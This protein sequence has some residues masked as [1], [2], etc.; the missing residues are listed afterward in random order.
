LSTDSLFSIFQG[1]DTLYI[2]IGNR[3][4]GDDG[5]GPVIASRLSE[6]P[7]IRIKDAGDRPERAMNWALEIR[8][9]LVVFIDASD[10]GGLAGEIRELPLESISDTT[11]STHRIPL[12]LIAGWITSETG[13]ECRCIGIQPVSMALGEGLSPEVELAAAEIVRELR[14]SA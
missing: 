2:T 7:D 1:S 9:S 3:L 8:P 12:P 13:A 4:R 5:A 14:G 6:I 10:F 11:F